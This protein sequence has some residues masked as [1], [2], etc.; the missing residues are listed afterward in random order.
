M[1]INKIA[2]VLVLEPFSVKTCKVFGTIFILPQ[3]RISCASKSD[4]SDTG[5][6]LKVTPYCN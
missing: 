5:S 4:K 3:R 1:K 6:D 2:E